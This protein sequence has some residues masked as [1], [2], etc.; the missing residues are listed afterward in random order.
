MS[1]SCNRNVIG[2]GRDTRVG[3]IEEEIARE[4]EAVVDPVRSG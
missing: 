2:A 1:L 3:E 4:A